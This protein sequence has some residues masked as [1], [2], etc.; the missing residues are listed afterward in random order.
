MSLGDSCTL[1]SGMYQKVTF[2][3]PVGTDSTA[4]SVVE[5]CYVFKNRQ[6]N[7]MRITKDNTSSHQQNII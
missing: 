2:L 7:A 5:R 6:E 1:K 4:G 3:E